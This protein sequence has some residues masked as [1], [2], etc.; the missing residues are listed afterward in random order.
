[1]NVYFHFFGAVLSLHDFNARWWLHDEQEPGEKKAKTF[2][3]LM[4][5]VIECPTLHCT[6][7]FVFAVLLSGI[8]KNF[9]FLSE[10]LLHHHGSSMRS[11]IEKNKKKNVLV[12]VFLIF[13]ISSDSFI[14]IIPIPKCVE[15]SAYDFSFFILYFLFHFLLLE[16]GGIKS[17][18]VF[19]SSSSSYSRSTSAFRLW[20][21]KNNFWF[22][23]TRI[24]ER[25]NNFPLLRRNFFYDYRNSE[26]EKK[27]S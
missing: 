24:S 27:S 4:L 6:T 8:V 13:Y 25:N 23:W 14:E 19:F 10:R 12:L 15:K 9:D 11:K 2:Q 7:F 16:S 18:E 26:S 1:M 5:F 22:W 3:L 21:M 20:M 17:S